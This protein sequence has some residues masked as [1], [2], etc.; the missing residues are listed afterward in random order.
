[1]ITCKGE[2]VEVE[3]QKFQ[4]KL[5]LFLEVCWG[6]LNHIGASKHGKKGAGETLAERN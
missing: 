4:Q 6:E 3:N 2:E 5:N 1:M